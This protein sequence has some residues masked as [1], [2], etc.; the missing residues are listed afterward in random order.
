[1]NKPRTTKPLVLD[2]L[3]APLRAIGN[4]ASLEEMQA[5]YHEAMKLY[6]YLLGVRYFGRV[7]DG[8]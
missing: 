8:T 1:M 4:A 3:E 7:E 6:W 5:S 2:D